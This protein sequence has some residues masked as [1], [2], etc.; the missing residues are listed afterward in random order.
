LIDFETERRQDSSRISAESQDFC[1]D[2]AGAAD[3]RGFEGFRDPARQ[4]IPSIPCEAQSSH[5]DS[6]NLRV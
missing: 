3:L 6:V 1:N 2:A 4:D 5:P